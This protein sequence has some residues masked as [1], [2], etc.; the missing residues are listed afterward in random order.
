MDK[1]RCLVSQLYLIGFVL[2]VKFGQ[3]LVL[4]LFYNV[5][6][7]LDCWFDYD[8]HILDVVR[9]AGM[10]EFIWWR[11]YPDPVLHSKCLN[12][13]NFKAFFFFFFVL[14]KISKPTT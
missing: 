10:I 9:C 6:D 13:E 4:F 8:I 1:K 14:V 12:L 3:L 7:L 5:I 11:I 2:L